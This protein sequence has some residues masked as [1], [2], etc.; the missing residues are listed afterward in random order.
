LLSKLIENLLARFLSVIVHDMTE[1]GFHINQLLRGVRKLLKVIRSVY[2][3]NPRAARWLPEN[4]CHSIM[5]GIFMQTE[6]P[7]LQISH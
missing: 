4:G 3:P 7:A 1:S 5:L 2:D 6:A